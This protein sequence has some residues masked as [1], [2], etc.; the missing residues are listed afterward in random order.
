MKNGKGTT[1]QESKKIVKMVKVVKSV[2][3]IF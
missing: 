2:Q 3:K 1:V